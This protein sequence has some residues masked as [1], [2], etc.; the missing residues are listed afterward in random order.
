GHTHTDAA[1][2]VDGRL[3]GVGRA[4][5]TSL[6]LLAPSARGYRVLAR[7]RTVRGAEARSTLAI[8]DRSKPARLVA[9]DPQTYARNPKARHA[10]RAR[11]ATRALRPRLSVPR[12]CPPNSHCPT[13]CRHRVH[14]GP[15]RSLLGR[16]LLAWM[17]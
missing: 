7:H 13:P 4:H 1:D 10:R 14:K 12:R 9:A 16:L 17:P 5:G 2:P 3:D 8:D 15:A 6:T 11:S